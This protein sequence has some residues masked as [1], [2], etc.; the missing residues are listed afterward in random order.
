MSWTKQSCSVSVRGLSAQKFQWMCKFILEL[1]VRALAVVA[2]VCTWWPLVGFCLKSC[3]NRKNCPSGVWE[4]GG[5]EFH[6]TIYA[7]I[8]P[9]ML[10]CACCQETGKD[11]HQVSCDVASTNLYVAQCCMSLY[12]IG[13]CIGVGQN[14]VH[15]AGFILWSAAPLL[16]N[17]LWIWHATLHFLFAPICKQQTAGEHNVNI[18]NL[19][20]RDMNKTSKIAKTRLC[21]LPGFDWSTDSG[22]NDTV[23]KIIAE[24][25]NIVFVG[26]SDNQRSFLEMTLQTKCWLDLRFPYE[27]VVSARTAHSIQ[28][29]AHGT[30]M[31]LDMF[32]S[33]DCIWQNVHLFCDEFAGQVTKGRKCLQIM[34]F[35]FDRVRANIKPEINLQTKIWTHILVYPIYKIIL[36]LFLLNDLHWICAQGQSEISTRILWP[37]ICENIKSTCWTVVF[38][39]IRTIHKT[40]SFVRQYVFKECVVSSA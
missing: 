3:Q 25:N 17:E 37:I 9:A 33:S 21:I 7:A 34:T 28:A 32:N 27:E 8:L 40:H 12:C 2:V 39:A 30:E 38:M 14:C 31:F 29:V 20:E 19:G 4:C 5:H 36:I 23:V 18:G 22:K 13:L 15:F 6:S 1:C 26:S 10:M 11:N 24:M 16:G 35:A